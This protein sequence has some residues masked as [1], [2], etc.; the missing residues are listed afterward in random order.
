ML[1]ISQMIAANNRAVRARRFW[2]AFDRWLMR[3]LI[4]ATAA[5]LALSALAILTTP[6]GPLQ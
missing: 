5:G 2:A 3:A 4:A 6:W 1:T